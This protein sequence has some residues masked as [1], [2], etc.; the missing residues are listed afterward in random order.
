L[1][2]VPLGRF[3]SPLEIARSAGFLLSDEAS[4]VTGEVLVADGGQWL[5][6]QV[7]G[8]AVSSAADTS[9]VSSAADMRTEG[10]R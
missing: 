6:K 5:G 4:F 10:S 2:S 8:D 1:A 9:A 3:A 7:Y